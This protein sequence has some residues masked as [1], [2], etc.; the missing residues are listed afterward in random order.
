MPIF[1]F[2]VANC[3]KPDLTV[4]LYADGEV[5]RNRI[6]DRNPNDPDLNKD[7]FTNEKY[8][9]AIEFVKRYE[10][11]YMLIDNTNMSCAQTIET[12]IK[13]IKKV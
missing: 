10:M 9:K 8:C 5:R 4:I 1:D 3:P 12:I 2:L 11:N 7:I 6:I 13:E